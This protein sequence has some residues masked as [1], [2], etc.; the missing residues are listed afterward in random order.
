MSHSTSAPSYAT[1]C[2]LVQAHIH[3]SYAWLVRSV[4]SPFQQVHH[5]YCSEWPGPRSSN[6]AIFVELALRGV[7]VNVLVFWP[8]R[9]KTAPFAAL[10][11]GILWF[12][13]G[14]A[15]HRSIQTQR[16]SHAYTL[17]LCD[18][19]MGTILIHATFFLE[20]GPNK[21]QEKI[22][23]IFLQVCSKKS[24]I[25]EPKDKEH[26]FYYKGIASVML[27]TY[28]YLSHQA[29]KLLSDPEADIF[30]LFV[31]C[32]WFAINCSKTA[33]IQ[34]IIFHSMPAI[35]TFP[36]FVMDFS[37]IVCMCD[38]IF[39][40]MSCF[41]IRFII[42][43]CLIFLFFF[44][45][46]TFLQIL[47]LRTWVVPMWV[48]WVVS[49]LGKYNCNQWKSQSVD[50]PSRAMPSLPVF[51]PERPPNTH[52]IPWLKMWIRGGWLRLKHAAL[53]WVFPRSI[54]KGLR[55]PQQVREFNIQLLS[56]V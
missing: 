23:R 30:Q 42:I 39:S 40:C 31:L 33:V 43:R 24:I 21:A 52:Y 53:L 7:T 11:P 12:P 14:S 8:S 3:D 37:G 4:W 18:W 19:T 41:A 17:P 35:K 29:M 45:P 28:F 46:G 54:F 34:W 56:K 50:T 6:G 15:C 38:S 36:F 1:L 55:G 25:T 5:V 13:R 9:G 47:M 10:G 48:C 2:R 32:L 20:C 16:T 27:C 44:F 49:M 22:Q 51:L 26:T